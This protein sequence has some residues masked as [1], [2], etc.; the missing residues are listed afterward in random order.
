MTALASSET[1]PAARAGLALIL[2][3]GVTQVAGYGALYY[4]FAVLAPGMTASLG[5]APDGP[6]AAS[7]SGCSQGVLPPPSPG[8]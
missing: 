5:W 8:A 3:L 6:V 2:A 4:A 7:L 1:N